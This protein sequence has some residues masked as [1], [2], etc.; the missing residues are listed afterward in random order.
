MPQR[1]SNSDRRNRVAVGL[2]LG[3]LALGGCKRQ[4]SGGGQLSQGQADQ[5]LDRA[6]RKSSEGVVFF[7]SESAQ[8]EFEMDRLNEVAQAL[9]TP[10]ALCFVT[11]AISEM[12]AVQVEG[13]FGYEHVPEGQAKIR[14]R[15]SQGG[16]VVATE[17]IDSGFKDEWMVDC[18][19]KTISAKRFPPTRSGFNKHIDIVYWV[20]LGVFAEARS[21]AFRD[22]MRRQQTQAALAAR[23]CLEGRV[24]PGHY[25]VEGLNLFDRKGNTIANRLEPGSMNKAGV[26]CLSQTFKG[27]RIHEE[28]EA[29]IRPASPRTVIDVAP[30]GTITIADEEWLRL[31]ELEEAAQREEKRRELLGSDQEL[32]DGPVVPAGPGDL[33]EVPA[34][35]ALSPRSEPEKAAVPEAK[36]ADHESGGAIRLG[37]R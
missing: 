10:L 33:G 20:G 36:P 26:Q 37:P 12:R 13:E 19:Q 24:E 5:Y 29:F 6:V 27:I 17:I 18:I 9:R 30:E 28:K 14:A 25:E 4:S 16:Q 2:V 31:L 35:E 8:R 1:P 21:E 11:R 34:P 3:A 15:I 22:H 32:I 23:S 7:P